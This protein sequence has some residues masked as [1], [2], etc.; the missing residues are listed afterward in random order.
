MNL[1][2]PLSHQQPGERCH[3]FTCSRALAAAGAPEAMTL[4]DSA[5]SQ[6]SVKSQVILELCLELSEAKV[7]KGCLEQSNMKNAKN[8]QK[9]PE[10]GISNTFSKI[11]NKRWSEKQDSGII[12]MLQ[13]VGASSQVISF[14][15]EFDFCPTW[16]PLD[17]V[18]HINKS[19]K[20]T[21]DW[22][23]LKCPLL[24]T[25]LNKPCSCKRNEK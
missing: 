7:S 5:S 14:L 19:L 20:G 9:E 11:W 16:L 13:G 12:P 22:K 15:L 1:S 10:N 3:F 8:R 21:K 2:W 23:P 18:W 24:R 4:G 6:T 17:F 25:W